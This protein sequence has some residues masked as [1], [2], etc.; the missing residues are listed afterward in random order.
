MKKHWIIL[1]LLALVLFLSCCSNNRRL[2]GTLRE[3]RATE[4]KTSVGI[5][6]VHD[7]NIVTCVPDSVKARF[8]IYHDSLTCSNC[9]I[10]HL[11]DEIELYKLADSLDAFDVLTIFSP[12][13]EEYDDVMKN[14]MLFNFP[15]P[16]YV[17]TYGVFRKANECIPADAR[18][19][20]FLLD[21]T[22]HPVFVGNPLA[23]DNLWSLFEKALYN[24][25]DNDGV[26]K[27]K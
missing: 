13:D 2:S 3:F 11:Y 25:L 9:Q 5:E 21:I 14:L 18:F 16:V 22:G 8:V 27:E 17:D 19:H 12:R 1:S 7:Q 15:Y 4:I 6:R 23:T 10:N 26:Y 24:I 20:M